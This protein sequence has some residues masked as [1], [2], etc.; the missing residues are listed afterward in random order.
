MSQTAQQMA[1]R[2]D[3]KRIL[4]VEDNP[5]NQKVAMHLLVLLGY[6][7][8]LAE[9][10][11]KALQVI[12]DGGYAAVLMDLQ[13]PVMDGLAATRAIRNLPSECSRIPI[14]ALTANG[15]DS[16]RQKCMAVGMNDFLTKPI[17]K[18]KFRTALEHWTGS[19]PSETR[20][21]A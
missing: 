17:H 16:E 8:D 12:E 5:I 19:F 11:A 7:V 15:L 6:S 18:E 14:I 1:H 21:S 2:A 4:L 9:N 3:N 20:L 13:M 10:G